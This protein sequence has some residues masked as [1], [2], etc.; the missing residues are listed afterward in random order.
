MPSIFLYRENE[1]S[2]KKNRRENR[3]ISSLN[4]GEDPSMGKTAQKNWPDA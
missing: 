1:T 3:R 2:D 4:F